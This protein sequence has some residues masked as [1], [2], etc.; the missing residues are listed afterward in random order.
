M[1]I[2]E[3]VPLDAYDLK[4]NSLADKNL[5]NFDACS[6]HTE[7]FVYHLYARYIQEVSLEYF[8]GL[9]KVHNDYQYDQKNLCY[10]WFVKSQDLRKKTTG[11]GEKMIANQYNK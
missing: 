10:W 6:V 1:Y 11:K 9:C 8:R 4:F 7:T 3:T 2:H 5:G